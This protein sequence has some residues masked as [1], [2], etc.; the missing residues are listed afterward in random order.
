[1]AK[2]MATFEE[3]LNRFKPVIRRLTNF[4]LIGKKIEVRGKENFIKKGSNIIIGNHIGSFK[5]VAI[6]LKIVPRP[7]FFT[8]NKMLF[9]K[10]EFNFLIRKHLHR[11]MKKFGLF[12]NV[13]LTPLRNLFVNYISS[14]IIRVGT[15]PVDL[16]NGKR[17]A[18]EQCQE[19]LKRGRAIIALQGR[20]R[21]MKKE[22]NPY[23]SPFRKGSSIIAYNLYE[24][25]GISVPVTPL[26]FF[27]TQY[28]FMIP[29]KIKVNVGTPLYITDYLGK[30]GEETID[31]FKDA[32]EER[33]KVLFSEF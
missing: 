31:K 32:L 5:D 25:E 14:N 1:M 24:N 23:V 2:V 30:G 16:Y 17:L 20:G 18:I 19:Y 11:H 9:S 12:L 6:L 22:P 29:S 28:P 27:G 4:A 15:I 8:A 33:V 7:I 10:D 3:E 26:A 13:I 21:V